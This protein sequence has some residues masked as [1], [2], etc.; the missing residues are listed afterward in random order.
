[1]WVWVCEVQRDLVGLLG[2]LVGRCGD[3]EKFFFSWKWATPFH[4]LTQLSRSNE[5]P[6]ITKKNVWCC[7]DA[8]LSWQKFSFFQL[9]S[10]TSSYSEVSLSFMSAHNWRKVAGVFI[11]ST[12]T[13]SWTHDRGIK[14]LI[15]FHIEPSQ[16]CL[17]L[18]YF[19]ENWKT[20]ARCENTLEPESWFFQ[21][22]ST[23]FWQP[24]LL[25]KKKNQNRDFK[26][27]TTEKKN[28]VL[29]VIREGCWKK[30]FTKEDLV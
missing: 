2:W 30:I 8:K 4:T 25:K 13:G 20:V 1:M 21:M 9:D 7:F 22:N 14:R 5:T 10:C 29:K 6:A 3:L 23:W 19:D 27:I 18:D 15:L 17:S 26:D 24:V 28:S 16:G 12:S 11:K